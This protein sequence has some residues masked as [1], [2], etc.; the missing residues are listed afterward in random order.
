MPARFGAIKRVAIARDF[1]AFKRN[2]NLY[3][4][5]EDTSGKLTVPNI[6]LK[7]NLKNWVAQYKMVN[8]TIDIINARIVNF[9]IEYEVTIDLSANK[10]SVVNQASAMLV[11][12]FAQTYD[13]G[14]PIQI[15][16]ISKTLN[17]VPGVINVTDVRIVEKTG[18]TYNGDSY[19]FDAALSTDNLRI[20][21]EENVIFELKF[22][23]SD[24]KGSI[25]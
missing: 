11:Q 10:Y 12:Q 15:A 22:P 7:N 19:D 21:A 24:I 3:V 20:L 1:N 5:S 2:L 17:K 6:T 9:G 8:D 4:I 18:V 23:S 25:K 16:D 13:I 14:E